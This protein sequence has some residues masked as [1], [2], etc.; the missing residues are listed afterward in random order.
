MRCYDKH[1]IYVVE[2]DIFY[3]IYDKAEIMEDN[4]EITEKGAGIME[5]NA[6][7]T[8]KD[9]GIMED[10]AGI[11]KGDTEITADEQENVESVIS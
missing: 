9:A 2:R 3:K 7:I 6:E 5:D 10:D 4:A 1:D 11:M 8:E